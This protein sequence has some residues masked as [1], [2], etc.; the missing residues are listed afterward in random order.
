[1]IKMKNYMFDSTVQY[2]DLKL[3]KIQI[4]DQYDFSE[5][6][7]NFGW[8]ENF[9]ENQHDFSRITNTP[10]FITN[11]IQNTNLGF[12]DLHEKYSVAKMNHNTS[13][14]QYKFHVT[15]P[16]LFFVYSYS[17]NIVYASAYVTHPNA[18]QI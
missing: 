2:V 9:A 16:F 7:K 13:E 4:R 15:R 14:P 10:I 8:K 11:L 6:F 18:A 3:P 1:M 12:D 17:E 5:I